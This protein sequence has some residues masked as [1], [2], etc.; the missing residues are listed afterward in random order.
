MKKTH[1]L[2]IFAL[3]IIIGIILLVL[4]L[5]EQPPADQEEQEQ[6]QQEQEEQI[7]TTTQDGNGRLEMQGYFINIPDDY[8]CTGGLTE[9]YRYVDAECIPKDGDDYKIV[10]DFGLTVTVIAGDNT[11]APYMVSFKRHTLGDV[12]WVYDGETPMTIDAEHYVCSYIEGEDHFLRL[13]IGKTYDGFARYFNAELVRSADAE[14]N[15]DDDLVKLANFVNEAI[16][17]D[18]SVFGEE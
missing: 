17:I 5:S 9:G 11:Y 7:D 3:L 6:E 14:S 10:V 13:G 8:N 12:C 1:L 18:W 15:Q 2:V 16:D 4:S